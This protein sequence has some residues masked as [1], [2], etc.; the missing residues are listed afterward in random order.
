MA[1]EAVVFGKL[2]MTCPMLATLDLRNSLILQLK[3]SL[4]KYFDCLEIPSNYCYY[5]C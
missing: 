5:S 1:V 2:S 4:R 3:F